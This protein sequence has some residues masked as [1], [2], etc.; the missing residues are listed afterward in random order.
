LLQHAEDLH[1][2]PVITWCNNR[3]VCANR[4]QPSNRALRCDGDRVDHLIGGE[5]ERGGGGLL[6]FN[7][8]R[9]LD[10][11][12]AQREVPSPI[13][14]LAEARGRTGAWVDI[15]KPFW[16]D[17]PV[18]LASGLVNSVGIAHNHM[19]RGGV[20]PNE[21]WGRPRDKQRFPDPRGNGSWT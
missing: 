11:V 4:P 3:N 10:S 8:D 7:L 12:G 19:H 16:Y 6:Y 1:V 14:F 9:P 15:E 18:W 17:T 20:L 5:D 2:A 21:A 13:K